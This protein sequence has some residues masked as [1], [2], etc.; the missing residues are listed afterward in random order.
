MIAIEE[1]EKTRLSAG[2][3]FHT[4]KRQA[5]HNPQHCFEVH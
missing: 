2:R 3:A 4:A 5:F 1:L